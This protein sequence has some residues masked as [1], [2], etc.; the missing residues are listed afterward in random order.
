M[1]NEILTEQILPDQVAGAQNW[2]RRRREGVSVHVFR[3]GTYCAREEVSRFVLCTLF[4]RSLTIETN[5]AAAH[6]DDVV[7]GG[8][9]RIQLAFMSAIRCTNY[10]RCNGSHNELSP[11]KRLFNDDES[12]INQDR[13]TYIYRHTREG[14]L[15]S[16][17]TPPPPTVGRPGKTRLFCTSR[18]WRGQNPNNCTEALQHLISDLIYGARQKVF[19]GIIRRSNSSNPAVSVTIQLVWVVDQVLVHIT[20]SD[21]D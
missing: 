11:I 7:G 9:P 5:L 15:R 20:G 1:F 12:I 16:P 8:L 21:L 19:L 10:C 14:Q 2:K 18:T 17:P 4:R 3:S 6:C 13:H